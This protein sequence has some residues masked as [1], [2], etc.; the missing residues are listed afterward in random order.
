[1]NVMNHQDQ[2]KKGDVKNAK[3]GVNNFARAV[4]AI[5]FEIAILSSST[6]YAP[7]TGDPSES[8]LSTLVNIKDQR[9]HCT[10]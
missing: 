4:G 3:N 1:M 8:E 10:N 6:G 7:V 2:L 5:S 9:L